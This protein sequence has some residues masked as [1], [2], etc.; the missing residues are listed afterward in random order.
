MRQEY[1]PVEESALTDIPMNVDT[2]LM[3][4]AGERKPVFTNTEP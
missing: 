4:D 1:A 3:E 2:G